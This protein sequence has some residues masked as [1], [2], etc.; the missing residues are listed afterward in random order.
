MAFF[1][2]LV[3]SLLALGTAAAYLGRLLAGWNVAFAIGA[4][5]FSLAAG[6][7]AI[8]SPA[9][10]RYVPDPEIRKRG[11][12]AGAFIYGLLYTVASITTAAG[13]LL[14]LLTV[15]A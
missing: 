5:I 3:V 8:F 7:A 14:L 11:G 9:L 2:G 6:F 10:R 4:A 13:P 12:I 15:A 1:F